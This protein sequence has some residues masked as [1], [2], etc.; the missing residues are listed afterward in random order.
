VYA[1]DGGA[2]LKYEAANALI[3]R[4]GAEAAGALSTQIL[5]EFYSVGLKKL[6]LGKQ[7]ALEIV[8]D[9]VVGWSIG[10]ITPTFWPRRDC[11]SV[12]R[13]HGGMPSCFTARR[14]WV[15]RSCGRKT[16]PTGSGMA[17]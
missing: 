7:E 8:Q 9:S 12:T 10:R 1:H 16:W 3:A 11:I 2:G 5:I 17:P 13:F 4:L 15:A 6:A 14:R